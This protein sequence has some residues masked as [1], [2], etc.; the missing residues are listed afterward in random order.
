VITAH[1]LGRLT[2]VTDA[3]LGVTRYGYDA[4]GNRT[5]VTDANNHLTE[6]EIKVHYETGLVGDS[7]GDVCDPCP[8]SG[9]ATCAPTTCLDQDGDGY[10]QQGASACSEG[11]NN[12]DCDDANP[13]VHPGVTDS[14]DDVDNDCDRRKDEGCLSGAQPTTYQYKRVQSVVGSE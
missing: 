2:R 4:R 5:S 11:V 12:F 8:T 9:F 14:C 3:L 6:A 1:A 13:A 7:L 10:G